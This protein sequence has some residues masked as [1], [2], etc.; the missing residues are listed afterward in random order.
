MRYSDLKKP[1]YEARD[2]QI[3]STEHELQVL[4][5]N[6]KDLPDDDPVK[7]R[8]AGLL[9]NISNGLSN[10][11]NR[12]G[13]KAKTAESVTEAVTDQDLESSE[14]NLFDQLEAFKAFKA[15]LSPE[16]LAQFSTLMDDANQ[17]VNNQLKSATQQIAKE[18]EKL[19]QE[20]NDANSR[21][22]E[23]EKFFSG[24]LPLLRQLG[25]KVNDY[26]ELTDDD[27][28]SMTSTEKSTAKKKAVNAEKFANTLAEAMTGKV[29]KLLS[30]GKTST[31]EIKDFLQACLDGK[32][33]NLLDMVKSNK[34]LIDDYVNDQYKND[35]HNFVEEN[36][37]SYSPGATSGAI[38]PG[39]LALAMLGD[40]ANK[41]TTGGDLYIGDTLF[42]IK[43]GKGTS[44]G[45]MNSKKIVSATAGY[46]VWEK[47]I[48]KILRDAKA[49]G[50][51]K[52][53]N[54]KGKEVNI[55]LQTY[56]GSSHNKTG[57]G[58]KKGSRYN[59]NPSGIKALNDDVLIPFAAEAA[60]NTS[61]SASAKDVTYQLFHDSFKT[62]IG[63]W[64]DI[65]NAD[66]VIYNAVNED[67]TVDY[68][69]MAKAYTSLAYRSYQLADEVMQI[70]FIRTDTRHFAIIENH[71]DFMGAIDEKRVNIGSGFTWNDDQQTPTP[72]YLSAKHG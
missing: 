13:A 61:N 31:Q 44:G 66:K 8:L 16:Q 43:A 32:V 64:D 60:K 17:T 42:E 39:E 11:L 1:V 23:V 62:L 2:F 68:D 33:I 48:N 36:I 10:F 51:I 50:K 9:N 4:I 35:Y 21:A 3:D 18:N 47:G 63:N 54:N 49:E 69:T 22:K 58:Y 37:F 20:V 24:L 40:P 15:S 27:L 71:D 57:K 14:K 53:T 45:R 6:A 7:A 34:G 55:P 59:F 25:N 38:G 12:I 56:D 29:L 19:K 30:E 28:A 26:T 70:L 52:V 41:A 67:G 65:P 72:T 5:A 46:P